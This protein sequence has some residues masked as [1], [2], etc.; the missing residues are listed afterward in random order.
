MVFYVA[1][2]SVSSIGYS[3]HLTI[4]QHFT[5]KFICLALAIICW[6]LSTGF[7]F[8]FAHYTFKKLEG[9]SK[10]LLLN[11]LSEMPVALGDF[12]TTNEWVLQADKRAKWFFGAAL[13]TFVAGVVLFVTWRCVEMW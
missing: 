7:S 10:F 13:C 11:I 3:V 8:A 12:T 4:G 6:M 1:A 9:N 5:W 2:L